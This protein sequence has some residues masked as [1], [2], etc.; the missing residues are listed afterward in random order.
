MNTFFL[1]LEREK[2][3]QQIRRETEKHIE[4]TTGEKVHDW[5]QL[6]SQ[7]GLFVQKADEEFRKRKESLLIAN[8]QGKGKGGAKKQPSAKKEK[9]FPKSEVG[10][11]GKMIN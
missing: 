3:R 2:I 8:G 7:K 9:W 1:A 6:G 5:K 10:L 11:W 4:T